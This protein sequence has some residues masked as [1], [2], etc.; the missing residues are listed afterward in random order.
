M[1][2]DG[3]QVHDTSLLMPARLRDQVA[4]YNVPSYQL[5]ADT[6][7]KVR[8]IEVSIAVTEDCNVGTW[9]AQR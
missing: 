9:A 4:R 6:E 1:Q 3:S 5:P 2:R 7:Q 8:H